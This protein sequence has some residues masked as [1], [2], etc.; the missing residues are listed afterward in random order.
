[1]RL[2]TEQCNYLFLQ[3]LQGIRIETAYLGAAHSIIQ[4]HIFI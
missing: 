1:M 4:L 2:F 3:V